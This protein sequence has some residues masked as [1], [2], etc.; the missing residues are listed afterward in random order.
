M[1][2]FVGSFW[3]YSG[4]GKAEQYKVLPDGCIDL[5]FN[6]SNHTT[7]L[8]GVMTRF[9][10]RKLERGTDLI[11]I[12][13]KTG[14]FKCF[15]NVFQRELKDLKIEADQIVPQL[16][17]D[18]NDRLAEQVSIEAK[19]DVLQDI[20]YKL[21]VDSKQQEDVLMLSIVDK[22]RF[23]GNIGSISSLAKSHCI[24]PRQLERRFKTCTGLTVKEFTRIVR[25]N[26]ARSLIRE[27]HEKNLLEIAF[28][29]GFYDHA[30]LTNEFNRL[31]GENPSYFR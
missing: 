24:S 5:I 25:F 23:E 17:A 4:P 19:I 27:C 30:H 28:D 21:V 2:D 10:E 12:R 1:K 7:T 6:L 29:L 31:S 3:T 22:I 9:A 11:G 8:S 15:T 18:I 14:R 26:S 13:F 16:P 20:I